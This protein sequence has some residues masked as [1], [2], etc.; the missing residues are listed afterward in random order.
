M[1]AF[2]SE[3]VR[4]EGTLV[5]FSHVFFFFFFKAVGHFLGQATLRKLG[6]PLL[7]LLPL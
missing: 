2:S 6:K 3:A 1:K 5:D 7:P 4:R